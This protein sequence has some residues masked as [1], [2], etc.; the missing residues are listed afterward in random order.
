M[1][2]LHVDIHKKLTG[3]MLRVKMDVNERRLGLLGASGSG[4]SMTLRM[5]AGI[6]TP[7]EGLIVLNGR[8]LFDSSKK[9]NLPPNKRKVGYLFQNYALFP[10]MTVQE[11]ITLACKGK[12]AQEKE[13]IFQDQK[14]FFQLDGLE[15]RYPHALS[16]GQ[17]QRVALARL[18]ANEPDILLLDEPFS[19]LDSYLRWQLEPSFL[20][21]LQSVSAP[22]VYVSHSRDEAYRLCDDMAIME[23][24]RI[25]LQGAKAQV[26]GNPFFEACARLT[27][28]KNI[29]K[30]VK[31]GDH[32]VFA[33]DWNLLLATGEAV[34]DDIAAI[35]IRAHDIKPGSK[36]AVNSFALPVVLLSEMPFSY[37]VLVGNA[38]APIQW[39][40]SRC[41]QDNLELTGVP[42][43]LAFPPEKLLL[44]RA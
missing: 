40:T 24:G 32:Q 36:G 25:L 27:G 8:T 2:G 20:K 12:N 1:S 10:H 11:N 5:I 21:I 13:K 7:D 16:G 43:W 23:N 31:Q 18:L 26:F 35:G 39:E 34:P 42:E 9:I 41:H 17:Q 3:F 44:L 14:R 6:D 38:A 37:T 4:K 28:C 22:V 15:G 30:A 19:A 29:S 33:V